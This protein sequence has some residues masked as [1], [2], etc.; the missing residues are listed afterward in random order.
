MSED[1]SDS[2]AQRQDRLSLG[3]AVP[4]ISGMKDRQRSKI[5]QLRRALAADGILTLDEQAEGSRV[6]SKYY[7]EYSE[8]LI[9]LPA[10]RPA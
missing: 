6:M 7:V 8:Q 2:A 5:E 4:D 3:K 10:S 9:R 1:I